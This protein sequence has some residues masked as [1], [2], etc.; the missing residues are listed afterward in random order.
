MNK[1]IV[2][3][4]S[5]IAI[6]GIGSF[7]YFTRAPSAPTQSIED[8]AKDQ[9]LLPTSSSPSSS[10]GLYSISS[11]LSMVE[12]G[13]DEVLNDKQNHV[14][15]TT[16]QIAG[17]LAINSTEIIFGPIKINA[18]TFVT[19]NE[20]RDGAIARFILKSEDPANEFIVFT[21]TKI[22]GIPETIKPDS[23]IS[24]SVLGDMTISGV[25]KPVTFEV[26][27]KIENDKLK[28]TA[29]ANLKR[30]D[31]N[32]SVPQ[33]PAVASVEDNF[34]VKATIVASLIKGE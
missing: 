11:E 4:F 28:G 29:T 7:L 31:F 16:N 6:L 13:I 27:G 12:F 15:G 14:V 8:V 24:L 3:G 1:K 9:A 5:V 25:T 17:N 32:L 34:T 10:V 30:S 33:V 23:I 22:N 26:K 2:I 21:P 18:K 20:R 19:D